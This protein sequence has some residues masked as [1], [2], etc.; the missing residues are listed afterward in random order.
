[1]CTKAVK[2]PSILNP[3]KV[4][5]IHLLGSEKR[6]KSKRG[7][8]HVNADAARSSDSEWN[9][10]W[11][12]RTSQVIRIYTQIC[13]WCD[14]KWSGLQW[15]WKLK[16]FNYKGLLLLEGRPPSHQQPFPAL[17]VRQWD[18]LCQM[19]HVIPPA[20][21]WSYLRVSTQLD[22]PVTPWGEASRKDHQPTC[23]RNL[24][25]KV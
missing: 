15:H 21:P 9:S 18:F 6:V 14:L 11:W 22:V 10:C 2:R 23:H 19:G 20:S 12:D 13:C 4:I 3:I 5:R 17:P 8:A 16:T 7:C 24:H 1:M 25:L